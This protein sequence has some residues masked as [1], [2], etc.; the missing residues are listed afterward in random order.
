MTRKIQ[1]TR[2]KFEAKYKDCDAEW[3]KDVLALCDWYEARI[4]NEEDSLAY[5]SA[6][7]AG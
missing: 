2:K 4:K 7:G 6:M 3:K 5:A 1:M